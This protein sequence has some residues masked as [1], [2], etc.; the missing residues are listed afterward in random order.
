MARPGAGPHGFLDRDWAIHR[1][2]AGDV[3]VMRDQY[4]KDGDE[5]PLDGG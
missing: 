3:I 4:F 5:P 2:K 1:R